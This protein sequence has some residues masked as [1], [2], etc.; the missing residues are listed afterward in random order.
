MF[1][2]ISAPQEMS[3]T[4]LT[5]SLVIEGSIVTRLK[6]LTDVVNEPDATHLLMEGVMVMDLESGRV[7][8]RG[9][10]AQVRLSDVLLLHAS[11]P[12]ESGSMRMPKQPV[13]GTIVIPPFTVQGT[14][15]LPFETELRMALDSYSERFIPVTDA[16]YWPKGEGDSPISVDL[17]V[18]NHTRA[19]VIIGPDVVW[20]GESGP[21]EE[22]EGQN[23]W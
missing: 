22:G 18:V 17:L 2:D 6:R 8:A 16:K 4:L 9:A 19:H 5:D 20:K 21:R 7:V 1:G 10:H 12:G 3:L 14:I 11:A 15:Y 13:A 23:P